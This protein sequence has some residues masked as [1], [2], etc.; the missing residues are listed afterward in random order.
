MGEVLRCF[1]QPFENRR[2]EL[3]PA[4]VLQDRDCDTRCSPIVETGSS[5]RWAPHSEPAPW[6]G[7]IITLSGSFES[8]LVQVSNIIEAS[9]EADMSSPIRSGRPTLPMNSVSPVNIAN[10]L[11]GACLLATSPHMLS[12]VWPGVSRNLTTASP[13]CE[14]V[15]FLQGDV[16]VAG[17]RLL[18]DADRNAELLGELD[19]AGHEVGVGV[20]QPHADDLD[21]FLL[22]RLQVR[23]D[24]PARVDHQALAAAD[25]HVGV[26][27]Q[28]GQIELDDLE[29][30]ELVRVDHLVRGGFVAVRGR[31]GVL[32]LRGRSPCV[33]CKA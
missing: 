21:A 11:S 23:E 3:A 20:G 31:L 27:R 28:H 6:A 22:G 17:A 14:R 19:M 16:L 2:D 33:N 26:V 24:V 4:L 15:V 32:D 7:R 12:G 10:G 1:G 30:G 8:L 29:A 18:A 5:L 9:V 25:E 13:T